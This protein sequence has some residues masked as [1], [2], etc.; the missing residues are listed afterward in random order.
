MRRWRNLNLSH[1]DFRRD[2]F[3][4]PEAKLIR[5]NA[6]TVIGRHYHKIKEEL[7]ILSEGECQMRLGVSEIQM[8]IGKVYEVSPG[9]YHEFSLKK[10]S[11]LIGL[12]SRPYDASDDYRQEESNV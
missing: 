12:N 8:E 3:S 5:A 6:D 7:F 10:G 9:T 11:V 1:S 2:L 4:F